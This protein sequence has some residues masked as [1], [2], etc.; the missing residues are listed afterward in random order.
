M[1]E[2]SRGHVTTLQCFVTRGKQVVYKAATSTWPHPHQMAEHG[3]W[4]LLRWML[5]THR[6]NAG[7]ICEKTTLAAAKQG[8][9]VCLQWLAELTPL[10][11]FT[12]CAQV[13]AA[14]SANLPMLQL[15]YRLG[16]SK[17]LAIGCIDCAISNAD[18][19]ML[20]WIDQLHPLKRRPWV[21]CDIMTTAS[22]K[23][24]LYLVE[25]RA[26]LDWLQPLART[27]THGRL[28]YLASKGWRG[29]RC[30]CP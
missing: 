9:L 22:Y 10:P 15:L 28:L 29:A 4:P 6:M 24:F 30:R 23:I 27:C 21:H 8:R 17:V 12:C 20:R 16:T 2:I 14:H 7:V 11:P 18:V 1:L 19:P 5:D 3:H 25:R 26:V 13:A